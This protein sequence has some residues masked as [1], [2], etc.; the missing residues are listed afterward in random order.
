MNSTRLS[1]DLQ[2]IAK[3]LDKLIEQSAGERV[4]FTL[5]VFTEGRASYISTAPRNESVR[6]IKNL[7]EYWDSGMPDVKA[8]DVN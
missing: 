1:K 8:H 6:E 7:L 5:M 4:A 3:Q 2:D